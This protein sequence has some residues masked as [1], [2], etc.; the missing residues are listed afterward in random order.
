MLR[1][2]RIVLRPSRSQRA[3]F[4]SHAGA[5]R[6]AWNWGLG[7]KQEAYK[8]TGKS[9]SAIDLHRELNRLKGLPKEQGG[10][11]WAYKISKCAFQESLRDLDMGFKRFFQKLG[12]YPRFKSRD[13]AA[14]HFRLTGTIRLEGTHIQ[15]PRIGRV[16]IAPGDRGYAPA[17]EYGSVSLIQEQGRWFASVRM[18]RRV[19]HLPDLSTPAEVG[20]DLGVR[21]LAMLSDGTRYENPQALQ[22]AAARL[23]R[24]QKALSRSQRAS[25][26]RRKKRERVACLH[27]RV[28]NLRRD[29]LHKATRGIVSR[30]KVVAIEDL[31]VKNMTRS[32]RGSVEQPGKRVRQK[33]GL[34]R[35]LLDASFAEFRRQL[36]Y[37]LAWRGGRVVAVPSAYTSQRCSCCGSSNAPGTS[38]VYA[39]AACGARIDRDFNAARNILAAASC[40]EAQN[41]RGAGVR[42][43]GVRTAGQ[44]ALKRERKR[45]IS[46]G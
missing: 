40:T 33:A 28:A 7:R 18:D 39:C 22:K 20:I 36:E 30:F 13:R 19:E 16:R 37:K 34:N 24:A 9:P 44:S 1:A 4:S 27:G 23:R 8:A 32:A 35:V 14:P 31:R 42:P 29:A 26:R 15:L 21:K 38:E 10:I 46:Y 5:A 12:R 25:A 6:W 43:G 17:G 3:V 41:A 11:P 2:F 45:T